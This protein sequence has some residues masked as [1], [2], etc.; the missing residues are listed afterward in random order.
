[1]SYKEDEKFAVAVNVF[2]QLIVSWLLYDSRLWMLK[3]IFSANLI[4]YVP[5]MKEPIISLKEEKWKNNKIWNTDLLDVLGLTS[6]S[7]NNEIVGY[8]PTLAFSTRN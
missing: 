7:I 6:S 5:S 3:S 2:Y 4:W 8:V 1:V